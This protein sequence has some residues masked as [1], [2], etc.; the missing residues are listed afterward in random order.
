MNVKKRNGKLEPLNLDKIHKMVDIACEG[1]HNVSAS[2]VEMRSGLQFYDGIT[3]KE[4]QDILIRS[5]SD[6]ISLDN[7]DYQYVAARLL[8]FSLRKDVFGGN[9]NLEFP[10]IKQHLLNNKSLNIYDNGILDEYTNEELDSINLYIHHDRDFIYTYAGLRQV[11]DKY[12][13]QDRVS[14]VIYETPQ[15]MYILIAMNVYRNENKSVRLKLVKEYYDLLSE[16]KIS[17][18]TPILANL[19]TPNRNSVSCVLID[20]DDTRDSISHSDVAMGIATS[21]GSGIGVNAGR[22]RGIGTPI[23]NGSV[24]S[25]GVIPFLKK[26]EST[27]RSWSQ[28][29]RGGNCTV[30]FPIWHQEI[31]DI[32][33]LKNNKGTDDN[34]VRKVDY[35]IQLSELFYKRYIENSHITLFSPHEVKDLYDTFGLPEFDELYVAYENNPNVKKKVVSA[36]KLIEDLIKES[37]ETG[38]VYVMNIDHANSHSPFKNK[39]YMT[40][41]CVAGDTKV[42]IKYHDNQLGIF[43]YKTI[44][45]KDLGFYLYKYKDVLVSSYFFDSGEDDAHVWSLVKAFA[46]TSSNAKVM[47]ITDS[48][49]ISLVLTPEHKVYTQNRGYVQAKD[50][51]L[52]EDTLV[53]YNGNYKVSKVK[54]IEYLEEEIPVYDITVQDTHNFFA[55]GILVHNCTEILLESKPIQHIDDE[56]GLIPTCILSGVNLGK[57]KNLSDLEHICY[58]LV[59]SLDNIIEWQKYP[60]VAAEKFTKKY[61]ALGLGFINFAYYLAKHKVAYDSPETLQLTHDLAEAYQYYCLKASNRIAK[62]RGAFEYF[63]KSKYSEG[64][65][66]IDTYKK[67]ID[68]IIPNNLKFDWESLRQDIMQYG[69]RNVT[70]TSQFP[71]ESCLFWKHKI[72]TSNGFMDFHQIAKYGNIDWKDIETN[73]KIGWYGLETPIEVETQEGYKTVDKL[74]FNGNKEVISITLENDKVIKCTSNHRFLVKQD[75]GYTVWKRVYE[76]EEGDDIVEI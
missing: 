69:L 30:N 52:Q 5:A 27:I 37:Y 75:D 3:T 60:I 4:I 44:E 51:I 9:W 45:I 76:L 8:L 47:K 54:N 21:T 31:E 67:S 48:N 71:A 50:L 46:R 24:V 11:F 39:V 73:N 63:E 53:T 49:G 34:R 1:L 68:S 26:F 64:I 29:T 23:R 25:N 62:E 20:V 61:R 66:P 12:L 58:H 43:E 38:R 18:P 19:R 14:N 40:N 10:S 56:N 13:V 36:R 74:Y 57:I 16:Q 33:V 6:L 72:N 7:P 65:L 28:G 55:N 15:F 70:L 22:L 35:C 41:L 2:Q 59:L 17:I 42:D 32:I